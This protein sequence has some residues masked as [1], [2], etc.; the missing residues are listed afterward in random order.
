MD[1]NDFT[2]EVNECWDHG[3]HYIVISW[4]DMDNMTDF[5]RFCASNDIKIIILTGMR[6]AM[7]CCE[8]DKYDELLEIL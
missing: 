4:F 5:M 6:V 1:F 7:N 3:A 2:V 8:K